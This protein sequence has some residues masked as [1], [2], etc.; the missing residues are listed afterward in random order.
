[1]IKLRHLMP[2]L[3]LPV[4]AIA[5]SSTCLVDAVLIPSEV[6][7][8]SALGA[9]QIAPISASVVSSIDVPLAGIMVEYQ[10]WSLDRPVALATGTVSA[11]VAIPGG[12]LPEE[13]FEFDHPIWLDDRARSLAD[14]AS[15]LEVRFVVQNALSADNMRHTQGP[16]M[17]GWTGSEVGSLCD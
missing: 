17:S 3:L 11:L 10:L 7:E 1:M 14:E 2:L 4:Q 12:L 16:F 15:S 8:K 9:S 13:A 6:L 5:E